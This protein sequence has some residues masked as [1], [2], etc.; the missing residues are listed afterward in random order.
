MNKKVVIVGSTG[1]IGG[2]VLQLCLRSED[3]GEIISLVRTKSSIKHE[4][5]TE[6]IVTDF[7]NYEAYSSFFNKIDIV[8]YCLGVYT[9]S[10][11]AALFRTINVDYPYNF[12]K[13]IYATSPNASFCLLSGQGAD[14]T[15]KSNIQFARDKGA[16][17]NAITALNFSSFYSFRPGYIYPTQKRVEPN[18]F[19]ALYR[20]LYPIIKLLGKRFSITDEQLAKTI[21]EVGLKG[22]PKFILE[23]QDI[24]QLN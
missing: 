19:Y 21:F 15:E 8:F 16:I 5:Y 12:A 23:N 24:R 1:M 13:T 6:Y 9:G 17:E 20:Y 7:L 3:V 11:S 4:K 10:V 14:R 2:K 18:I 22:H